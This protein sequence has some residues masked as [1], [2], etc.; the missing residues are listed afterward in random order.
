MN[1]RRQRWPGLG[2][3][4]A[5]RLGAAPECGGLRPAAGLLGCRRRWVGSGWFG[6]GSGWVQV[7]SGWFELVWVVRLCFPTY[8]VDSSAQL[9]WVSLEMGSPNNGG[10]YPWLLFNAPKKRVIT[11]QKRRA[12]F[13]CEKLSRALGVGTSNEGFGVWPRPW[14]VRNHL[15]LLLKVIPY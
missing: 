7:A 11:L 5:Q 14:H 3:A 12:H 2:S 10:I 1:S 15:L 4:A 6:F 9:V 8:E 13:S